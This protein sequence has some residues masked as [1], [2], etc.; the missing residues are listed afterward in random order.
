MSGV[1]QLLATVVPV[2]VVS[3]PAWINARSARETRRIVTGNGKGDVS[4]MLETLIDWQGEHDQH[5]RDLHA[6]RGLFRR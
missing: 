3:I 5:H 2:L 4:K 6:K 1:Q